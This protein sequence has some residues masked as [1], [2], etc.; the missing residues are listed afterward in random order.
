M[1]QLLAC[2]VM[3][4]L[5]AFAYGADRTTSAQRDAVGRFLGLDL[6]VAGRSA[7]LSLEARQARSG[8]SADQALSVLRQWAGEEERTYKNG[9]YSEG[10]FKEQ[11]AVINRWIGQALVATGFDP[12]R[13]PELI[14]TERVAVDKVLE[15][16]IK[17]AK[18]GSVDDLPGLEEAVR[19]GL[20]A[21]RNCQLLSGSCAYDRETMDRI[22][23]VMFTWIDAFG[24]TCQDQSQ[25]YDI[26]LLLSLTRQLQLLG[27]G[28][29]DKV[30]YTPE[31]HA[32]AERQQAIMDKLSECK[33]PVWVAAVDRDP[34]Y[35]KE[36][37]MVH[38]GNTPYGRWIMMRT[39]GPIDH[40]IL[41]GELQIGNTGKGN[42][43]LK[44]LD[45]GLGRGMYD[46]KGWGEL[47]DVP[48]YPK[49]KMIVLHGTWSS[50]TADGK[51]GWAPTAANFG[52]I[53]FGADMRDD[54]CTSQGFV[55]SVATEY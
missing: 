20:A 48:D 41:G 10:Q 44:G 29:S 9:T 34:P 51:G 43:S 38:C 4:G 6:P 31:E 19:R 18:T 25:S 1:K 24:L 28:L 39:E 3:M 46:E 27:A 45:P 36:R 50:R 11:M 23:E 35:D 5:S 47:I 14:E 22:L 52:D 21:E 30:N 53:T 49:L 33:I 55:G 54:F 42:Y 16:A 2:L 8:L 12:A 13:I 40:K 17:T 32:K 37:W 7:P 15:Q 26:T